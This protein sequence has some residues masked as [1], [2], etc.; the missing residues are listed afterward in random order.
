MHRLLRTGALLVGALGFTLSLAAQ[1]APPIRTGETS[2]SAVF[3]LERSQVAENGTPGFWLKGASAEAAVNL[4]RGLGGA[5][6]FTG[7]HVSNAHSGVNFG[8]MAFMA[9]PRYSF[10]ASK[11]FHRST[12]LF[13]ETLFGAAHA[14][15][16]TFPG[17][18]GVSTSASSFSMQAGGGFDIGMAHHLSLRIPE[19]DW[20]RTTLPNNAANAQNDLAIA[21]GVTFR[22]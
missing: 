3:D 5:A 4:W 15:D 12:Q 6:V 22:R 16:S 8:K 19:I 18:A 17:A 21:F 9:G 10:D 11:Y 7:E 14:F 20:V 2:I 1:E 13:A